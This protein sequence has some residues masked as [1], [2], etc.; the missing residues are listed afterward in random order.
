MATTIFDF[1]S[2]VERIQE[3]IR[4]Y[5]PDILCCSYLFESD[6]IID[7]KIDYVASG[8][9]IVMA[10][11]NGHSFRE[12]D[13]VYL[14][15]V[16]TN[17]FSIIR[18]HL[19]EQNTLITNSCVLSPSYDNKNIHL[20]FSFEDNVVSLDWLIFTLSG[21]EE[22]FNLGKLKLTD[23]INRY[24]IGFYSSAG[25]I[26]RKTTFLSGVPEHWRTSIKNVRGGRMAFFIDG[27][28]IENCEY[29][30]EI[31]QQDILLE[32]GT[33]YVSYDTETVNNEFDIECIVFPTNTEYIEANFED[34]NKNLLQ[35][36]GSLV[37]TEDIPSV[38]IKFKGTNGIIKNIILKDDPDSEFIETEGEVVSIPGSWMTIFLDDLTE[39]RW[40][41]TINTVPQYTDLTKPCPYAVIE[42]VNHRT[43]LEEVNIS[44]KKEYGYVYKVE[45]NSL[46]IGDT[47]YSQFH[48]N[49]KIEL[50]KED[51]N[52][53]NVF[54]NLNGYIYELIITKKDGTQIDILH[55]KTYKKYVPADIN[56]PI[57]VTDEKLENS[58]DLSAS[59]REIVS[60]KT[61]ISLYPTRYTI[62]IVQ[63]VPFSNLADYKVYAI[64]KEATINFDATSI[65]EYAS[66]YI[67][68]T[69]KQYSISDNNVI[70]L[71]DNIIQTYKYVAVEYISIEDF[72]YYFTNYER[73]VF[74]DVQAVILLEKD[75]L[76][77][78]DNIIVYVIPKDANIKSEFLYRVPSIQLINSIDYYADRY[79]ILEGSSYEIDYDN[80]EIKIE[81]S[82]R[83]SYQA[84]VVDYLKN[85]S[86]AI[87]Y[88]E[89]YNQYEVDIA[90]SLDMVYVNYNMREDGNIYEYKTTAIR[91]DS[92]KY[93]LL[94]KEVE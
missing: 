61:K 90:T 30:A 25:N 9:G 56:S 5:E 70:I 14:F 68:L 51:N 27:F 4:F 24:K 37:V 48:K 59:Y 42:T 89:E 92:N 35:K 77:T 64:P 47:D 78:S 45:D 43:T 54:R 31:E 49:L 33:Y 58:F 34:L 11:D 23:S 75:I 57:I 50:T 84:F 94:R 73:E 44:L 66:S 12:A 19:L 83:N 80:R 22:T 28:R 71:D 2:R 62:S 32:P 15:R 88:I 85:D 67:E 41:G 63:D 29:D 20:K 39:V 36:D 55:Q 3:G 79:D 86:Y 60:S 53:I 82:T 91:P 65:D 13:D 18:K 46:L 69:S 1:N 93:V 81:D 10:K 16:G 7:M 6:L 26:I 87:N 76:K 21:T 40:R 72:T 74:D 38:N 8:F 52:Q 17:D